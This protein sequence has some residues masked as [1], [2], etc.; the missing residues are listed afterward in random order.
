MQEKLLNSVQQFAAKGH[1]EKWEKEILQT[2]A[3]S[4]GVSEPILDSLI[5]NELRKVNEGNGVTTKNIKA[6][7]FG[8][9]MFKVVAISIIAIAV[10]YLG[11]GYYNKSVLAKGFTNRNEAKNLMSDGVK[12]GKWIEFY[13]DNGLIE[14]TSS[15]YSYY[16]LM[17]FYKGTPIGIRRTFYK[18][19]KLRSQGEIV[20]VN[21]DLFNGEYVRYYSNGNVEEYSEWNKGKHNGKMIKVSEKGDT[22]M[23]LNFKEN[24]VDGYGFYSKDGQ[25]RFIGTLNNGMGLMKSKYQNRNDSTVIETNFSKYYYD[26]NDLLKFVARVKYKDNNNEIDADVKDD[27]FDG[28]LIVHSNDGITIKGKMINGKS[29]G[30]FDVSQ[31]EKLLF[32][33]SFEGLGFEELL[34]GIK[35]EYATRQSS[36][37]YANQDESLDGKLKFRYVNNQCV[38]KYCGRRFTGSR[39]PPLA[40]EI[41]KKTYSSD[42]ELANYMKFMQGLNG[43]NTDAI[44]INLNDCNGDFCSLKC[45]DNY[46]YFHH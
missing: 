16:C 42:P 32:K 17:C 20:S 40:I 38:C 22:T 3:T 1:I 9:R 6:P 36:L 43:Q 18:D 4:E 13:D 15:G 23:F 2:I 24:I 29:A 28:E 10:I 44:I 26:E 21:P 11:Y 37:N 27:S 39:Y 12:N 5:E 35:T 14:D 34:D 45:R 7:K 19:G 8:K 30:Q 25:S 41:G 46:N 33:K 31:N